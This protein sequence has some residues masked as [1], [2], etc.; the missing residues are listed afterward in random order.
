LF[1]FLVYINDIYNV[2]N[3]KMILFED[4]S[5]LVCVDNDIQKQINRSKTEAVLLKIETGQNLQNFLKL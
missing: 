1:L 3:S 2:C 4:D 5:V